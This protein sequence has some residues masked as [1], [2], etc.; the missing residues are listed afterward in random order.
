[1]QFYSKLQSDGR[2]ESFD[3]IVLDN[4]GGDLN[5]AIILKGSAKQIEGVRQDRAWIELMVEAGYCIEGVGGVSGYIGEGT[6]D[7]MSVYM[8]LVG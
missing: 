1:M 8:K 6:M 5:G 4:H 3:T 7:I 2:I